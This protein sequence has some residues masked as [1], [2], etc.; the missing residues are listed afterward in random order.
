MRRVGFVLL[1]LCAG[2]ALLVGAS[3]STAGSKAAKISPSPAFTNAQLDAYADANWLTTGGDLKNT[4]YSTLKGITKA[5]VGNLKLAWKINLGECPQAAAHQDTTRCPGQEE[6]AVVDNG[7]MYLATSKSEAFAIDATTGDVLWHYVP[8]WDPGFNVGNGGRQPGP[9]IGQGLMFMG[10]RDGTIVALDQKTGAVN[11]KASMGPWQKGIRVS[12]TPIY[13]EGEVIVGNSGGDGGSTSNAMMAFNATTGALLWSWNIIPAHHQ[14]G[15]NSWPWSG[16]GSN[17]GGGAMWNNVAIDTKRHMVFFGT[18]NPVPWNSRGPGANLWTDALVA[19]DTRTGA[20]KWGYQTVKHDLWDSDFPNSPILHDMKIDGKTVPVVTTVTKFGWTWS[21][22]RLTGKP[23]VPVAQVKVPVSSA[24]GVNSAPV[25]PIPQT[26]NALF[27]PKMPNGQGRLCATPERWKGYVA[28]DGKP[29]KVGC[30]FDPYDTTQ[31]V[32]RPFE[33]M[34]WP[35]SSY[36][37]DT[38]S[39]ITCGVTN[40]AYA[41]EQLPAS[42]QVVR[43]TGGIG[44]GI[45]TIPDSA[46][47]P[48]NLNDQ[49]NFSN[50]DMSTVSPKAGGKWHWHQKWD[51]PCYSGSVNTA[52]GVTFVGHLGKGDAKD[53]KGYLAAVDTA[54]GKELWESALMDAPV[55]APPVTYSVGGKQYV[56]VVVGGESHNDPTRP[57]PAVPSARVRGDSVYTFVLG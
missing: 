18:G 47:D 56:S 38:S 19:L 8:E 17:Y 11:W 29:V 25:Q 13:F 20:F 1:S 49:G 14:P 35:A 41:M 5:N 10:Q 22:N 9:A 30:H 39:F 42:S 57:N 51:A 7:V 32:A 36:S 28:P 50:L 6:N 34:D 12:A 16:T 23:V 31:F 53:G 45:I 55:G 40:R 3:A 2:L 4:R 37:P 26:P 54:S 43:S 15:G 24:P 44:V 27:D 21:F 33:S 46:V 48:L 52:T